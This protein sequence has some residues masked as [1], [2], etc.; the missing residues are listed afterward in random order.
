MRNNII[1]NSPSNKKSKQLDCLSQLRQLS[2]QNIFT[3]FFFQS[4]THKV[5]TVRKFRQYNSSLQVHCTYTFTN[6]N[7][8]YYAAAQLIIFPFFHAGESALLH[9]LHRL[10]PGQFHA[11]LPLHAHC[12]VHCA[13]IC[14]KPR[15]CLES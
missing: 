11:T 9:Y 2:T 5:E 8:Y 1:T 12:T 13:L 14:I 4:C 10:R 3:S 15:D 7:F 6:H